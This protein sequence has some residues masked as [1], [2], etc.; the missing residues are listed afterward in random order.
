M[1]KTGGM[2]WVPQVSLILRDLEAGGKPTLSKGGDGTSS[3]ISDFG[4]P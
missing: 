2:I 1:T 3:C 4:S